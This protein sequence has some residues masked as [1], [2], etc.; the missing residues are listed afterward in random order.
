MSNKNSSF[1]HPKTLKGEAQVFYPTPPKT[2]LP[3]PEL[4]DW[5]LTLPE[6]VSNM[7]RNLE[8]THWITSY[9]IHFTG[10]QNFQD[11]MRNKN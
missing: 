1:Q 8:R 6:R 5:A 9:Q 3:N 7:L 10:A 11:R 4:R 2:V